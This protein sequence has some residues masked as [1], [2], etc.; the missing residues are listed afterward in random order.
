[1]RGAWV[2]DAIT[3]S[4]RALFRQDFHLDVARAERLFGLASVPP[5]AG[6]AECAAWFVETYGLP[7]GA[8]L[9]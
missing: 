8:G 5:A 3:P 4:L 9:S 1:M 2:P 7:R 6:L